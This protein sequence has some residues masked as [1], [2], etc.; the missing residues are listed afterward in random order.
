MREKAL[1]RLIGDSTAFFPIGGNM[2]SHTLIE[3]ILL[4]AL[5]RGGDFSEV[6]MEQTRSSGISII[7]QRVDKVSSGMDSGIGIRIL[8]GTRCVY[9]YTNDLREDTLLRLAVEASASLDSVPEGRTLTLTP[10][11]QFE[12]NPV[13]IAPVGVAKSDKVDFLKRAIVAARDY[14]P[15]ITQTGA[16]YGDVE[17]TVVIANSDGLYREDHRARV[18]FTVEAIASSEIEKQSGYFGP[19]SGTGYEFIESYPV[20]DT[21]RE[22]ARIAVTM[23]GAGPCPSGKMPVVID[24]GFGGVIFHEACGHGLEAT[25]VGIHAS[26]FDGKLGQ[27]VANPLVS[28]VDDGTL[29][30][31]WGSIRIDDE[32]NDSRKNLLITNGILTGYMIDKLGGRRMG[33]EP[34]GSSR[35][36]NY[37]YAPTSRMTNT[38]IAAGD[39][40]PKDI[41]ADTPYGL[42]AAHMG[43]GSVDPATGEFNFAVDEAYMIRDGRI[44]EPVRGATLIGRG[45]QVLMNIDRVGN[46]FAFAQGVCGS[47]SGN[48]PTNVGQPMIRVSEMTV[49]GKDTSGIQD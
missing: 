41:I 26:V 21:A 20:E 48:V 5:S 29:A 17:K 36:Q 47:I 8:S 6:Y 37:K 42:Y 31:E 25:S 10:K 40:D 2:L 39:L 12:S 23:L 24:N 11:I 19:G 18:R 33:M 13:L 49:G 44:A 46:N 7:N 14:S 1:G 16:S 27:Q 32:G 30:G 43:G 4:A 45:S 22:A 35:R 28:A 15:L 34:T 9:V 38:Y 3:K